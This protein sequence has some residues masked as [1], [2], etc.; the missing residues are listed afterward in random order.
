PGLPDKLFDRGTDELN[1]FNMYTVYIYTRA[2]WG[3]I[4]IKRTVV[5]RDGLYFMACPAGGE[6]YIHPFFFQL[7]KSI[8]QGKG[9]FC[10]MVEYR[11]IHIQ[12]DCFHFCCLLVKVIY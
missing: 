11:T 8:G 4:S 6:K 3:D 2:A 7:C 1:G 12:G 5:R 9:E 10:F